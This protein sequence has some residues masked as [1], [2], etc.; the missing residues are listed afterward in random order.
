MKKLAYFITALLTCGGIALAQ[1]V[2]PA[3]AVDTLGGQKVINTTNKVENRLQNQASKSANKSSNQLQ[4]IIGKADTLITNRLNSLNELS[5]RIQSDARLTTSE[6]SS[7]TTDIQTG[8]SGLM[9]LKAKVDADKDVA[10]ARA[11]AKLVIT[12]YYI[13]AV[14]EPKIR[15][16]I[17]LNNMQTTLGYVEALVPQLQNL[18]NTLKSQGKDVS[19]IQPLLDDIS[20]QL[21]TT[22]TTIGTDISTVQNVSVSDK[23]T[24]HTTFTKVRQDIAQ[25]IRSGYAKIR[26]DFAKMRPLFKQIIGT[27]SGTPGTATVAP[28]AEASETPS[29]SPTPTQ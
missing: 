12:N 23:G 5:N 4:A 22:E 27:S 29:V 8:V 6:K 3:F 28:T 25:I 18:I 13:Y 19:Q 15:L 26:A 2:V 21:K 14:F 9:A 7:L 10:T 24:A 1:A 17:T 20:A 11:D 16:L